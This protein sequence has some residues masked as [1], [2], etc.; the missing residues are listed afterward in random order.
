MAVVVAVVVRV[1]QVVAPSVAGEVPSSLR[2]RGGEN[3][4][5]KTRDNTTLHA[6]QSTLDWI[7]FDSIRSQDAVSSRSLAGW[8]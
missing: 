2:A 4:V 5:N 6:T 1:V 7:R 3:T 8:R